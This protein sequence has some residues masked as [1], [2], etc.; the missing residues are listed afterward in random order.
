MNVFL[1]TIYIKYFIY[2]D[3][4]FFFEISCLFGFFANFSK[5]SPLF[6]KIFTKSETE[7]VL[8]M[9]L[10]YPKNRAS[11]PYKLGSYKKKECIHI[12]YC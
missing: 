8:K 12:M 3:I 7:H 10:K 4:R 2:H 1:D 5:N 11:C 9:F 6:S